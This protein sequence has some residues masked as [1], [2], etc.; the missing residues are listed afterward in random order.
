MGKYFK[1]EWHYIPDFRFKINDIEECTIRVNNLKV[2]MKMSQ[3]FRFKGN[4]EY[5]IYI[6]YNHEIFTKEYNEV[7]DLEHPNECDQF[8][9]ELSELRGKVEEGIEQYLKDNDKLT[10]V[11]Y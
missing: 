11:E 7:L 2:D 10:E 1:E 5:T 9:D 6:P 8:C 3:D 4:I